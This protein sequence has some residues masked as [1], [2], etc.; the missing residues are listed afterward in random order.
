[1]YIINSATAIPNISMH[2]KKNKESIEH[3]ERWRNIEPLNEREMINLKDWNLTAKDVN[4]GFCFLSF[5]FA[6]F[7][8]II[9]FTSFLKFSFCLSF[10]LLRIIN[11]FRVKAPWIL[12]PWYV[13][14]CILLPYFYF[15]LFCMRALHI[16]FY[17]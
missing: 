2:S 16:L 17:S 3:D 12:F 1:M 15:V 9:T 6:F 11:I 14:W 7:C 8:C 5:A 10:S 4:G 13:W